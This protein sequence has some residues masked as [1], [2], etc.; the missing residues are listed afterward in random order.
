MPDLVIHPTSRSLIDSYLARPAH[1]LLLSGPKGIGLKTIA[2][3]IAGQIDTKAYTQ[4]VIPDDKSIIAIETIRGLYKLTR[5]QRDT[6]LVVIID[7]ADA[8]GREAQNAFLKLL[9]EPTNN[10]Y[11]ILT[12]HAPQLLLAT[13]TSRTQHIAIAPVA[14]SEVES[15]IAADTPPAIKAQLL[16]IAAGLPA[17]IVRLQSDETYFMRSTKQMKDARGFLEGDMYTRLLFVKEYSAD[18]TA[19]SEFLASLTAMLSFMLFTQQD[20]SH[21][22]ALGKIEETSSRLRQNAHVRTQLTHL[23][24][25]L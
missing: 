10:I 13:I 14:K 25:Q 21:V 3:W 16:F 6:P 9:E 20:P 7:D 18:R 11:F 5:A 15:L 17:E 19:A 12:T 23:V 4:A 1:G 8:M 24:T 22:D 2:T